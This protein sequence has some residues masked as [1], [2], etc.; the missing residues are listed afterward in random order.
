ML[1]NAR[2]L[3]RPF[4]IGPAVT[5]CLGPLA[6]HYLRLRDEPATNTTQDAVNE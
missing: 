5:E 4:V 6:V 2:K 3:R 1:S